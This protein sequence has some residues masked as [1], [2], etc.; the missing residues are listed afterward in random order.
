MVH[1]SG[2]SQM[3]V[4][5]MMTNIICF[6]GERVVNHP[7]REVNKKLSKE[8]RKT[9]SYHHHHHTSNRTLFKIKTSF[10][11]GAILGLKYQ[12]DLSL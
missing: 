10:F 9:N 4:I 2:A 11:Q 5:K 6:R 12:I 1:K 3:R 8:E 7:S